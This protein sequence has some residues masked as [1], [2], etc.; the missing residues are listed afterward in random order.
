M[1]DSRGFE[2]FVGK[3]VISVDATAINV[4]H[5]TLD[6]GDIISIDTDGQFMG[7]PVVVATKDWA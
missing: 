2:K 4:V 6:N 5:F 3:T 1:E 7:I